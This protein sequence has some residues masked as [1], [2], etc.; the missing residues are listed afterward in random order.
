MGRNTFIDFFDAL[1]IVEANKDF[2]KTADI[3]LHW[4]CNRTLVRDLIREHEIKKDADEL[5]NS[6]RYIFL[7][8]DSIQHYEIMKETIRQF[9]AN[10]NP[11]FF[12]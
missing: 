11:L 1:K 9:V 6:D 3:L 7:F 2:F 8:Q 4:R 10:R 5:I 12:E